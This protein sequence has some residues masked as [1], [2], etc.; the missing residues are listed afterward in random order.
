M[1]TISLPSDPDLG[2]L[3]TQAR[4]LQRAVRSGD[5]DALGLVAEH[6]PDGAP[7]T[8]Q[9]AYPLSSAQLVLARRYGFPSWARLVHHV[10]LLRGLTR[11]PD[12][13]PSGDPADDLLRLGCLTY[14]TDGPDRWV[15]ARALLD[16]HPDLPAASI[17]AAAAA[18]D[19]TAVAA[20]LARDRHA[21]RHEGGP[22][23]WPPLLYLTYSRLDRAADEA[24]VLVIARLLLDAGADPD[25]GFLWHGLATPFTAL[26]GAFGGGEGGPER[27]RTIPT[28]HRSLACSSKRRRRQRRPGALQPHV[29]ARRLA[30]RAAVRVRARTRR[31]RS[32]AGPPRRCGRFAVRA[33]RGQLSWAVTH[34]MADRVRLLVDHGVDVRTP[35]TARS[36]GVPPG[37]PDRTPIDLARLHGG[38]EV[39]EVL[40]AAGVEVPT[41][42][43]VDDL[44]AA[45]LAGDDATVTRLLH[46]DPSG[47]LLDRVAAARPV[48]VLDAVD[49]RTAVRASRPPCGSAST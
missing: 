3:R 18:G 24:A 43:P 19:P 28:R 29:R 27:S 22:F 12:P 20:H 47:D 15:R 13:E 32:V 10:E 21:A 4:D 44:V 41:L 11:S 8:S 14:D 48:L 1:P 42:D 17:H 39:V 23:G 49:D 25:S 35:F 34:G 38:T 30:P 33:A 16:A 36:F 46:D 40:V 37:D 7:A 26:T 45:V 6:H 5:R 9:P 2:Q 31:R